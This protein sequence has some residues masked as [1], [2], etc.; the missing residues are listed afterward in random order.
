[1]AAAVVR[2]FV[3][4]AAVVHIVAAVAVRTVAAVAVCIEVELGAEVAPVVGVGSSF[5]V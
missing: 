5:L 3:V 2:M 4:V 1:M